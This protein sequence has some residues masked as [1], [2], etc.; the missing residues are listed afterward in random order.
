MKDLIMQ[1]TNTEPMK[2]IG[3]KNIQ[4]ITSHPFFDGID[5]EALRNQKEVC[6]IQDIGQMMHSIR[7]TKEETKDSISSQGP[8]NYMQKK[9]DGE[10][11]KKR[12]QDFTKC[13][14]RVER[15]RKKNQKGG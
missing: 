8:P 6:P 2:R 11:D 14:R 1:L 12:D 9:E 3:L 5:F 15:E 7:K 4:A 13:L 10:V